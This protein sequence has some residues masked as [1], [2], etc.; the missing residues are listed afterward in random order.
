MHER[1]QNQLMAELSRQNIDLVAHFAKENPEA[2]HYLLEMTFAEDEKL[3]MRASWT[4]EKLS[5]QNP[6]IL[7]DKLHYILK[8]L[9]KIRHSSTKRT[10]TKVLM[11]HAIPETY[12]GML[13]NFCITGIE[14][15]KEPIAVKANCMSLVFKLLPKYPD[16]KNEIYTLIEDQIPNNSVG[17][18]ARYKVLRKKFK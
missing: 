3:S 4:L 7:N 8:N 10:L 11:F 17:F 9:E 12:E 15:P 18:G 2:I 5:E 1:I 13:L 6:G 16:L 14:S